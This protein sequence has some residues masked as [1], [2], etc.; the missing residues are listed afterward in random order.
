MS[1]FFDLKASFKCLNWIF[2][3]FFDFFL[4]GLNIISLLCKLLDLGI[5]QIFFLYEQLS[6]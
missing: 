6:F 3:D 5:I 2:F 1:P 4:F